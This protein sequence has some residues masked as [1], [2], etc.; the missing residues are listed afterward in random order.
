MTGMI[1]LYKV[2]IWLE[3]HGDSPPEDLTPD[4][5][6]RGPHRPSQDPSSLDDSRVSACSAM[7]ISTTLSVALASLG[8][9]SHIAVLF[10]LAFQR[11]LQPPY[12]PSPRI[13]GNASFRRRLSQ[14][15]P[16]LGILSA[17]VSVLT[18]YGIT[19][20][21]PLSQCALRVV[22]FFYACQVL[23]L[24]LTKAASP[25]TKLIRPGKGDGGAEPQP[26][27]M[28]TT[29]DHAS[30]VW[31]LLTEMRY[32]SFD[33]HVPQAGR[34]T[35]PDTPDPH[36]WIYGPLILL[37]ALTYLL[38]I[39]P[40]KSAL[41][42]LV[43]QHSLETLHTLLHPRCPDTLFSRPFS[44]A[45]LAEFWGERW[46]ASASP[47]LQSLAYKPVRKRTGSRAMGVLATFALTGLWH[48]Y[49]A[50]PIS[51]RPWVVGVR[52]WAWFVSQGVGCLVEM[53]VW[54]K[55]QGDWVQRACV[56]GFALG[57]AGVC[58]RA[59]ECSCAYEGLRRWACG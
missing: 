20:A 5:V 55:R 47:F 18:P 30:Y 40:L 25:P 14:I 10:L 45:S 32:R 31:A 35:T 37:P 12:S 17:G 11:G 48:A 44:A 15:I 46:H 13:Q 24:A 29:R 41:L 56:W 1:R 6:T 4:T 26:A 49:A 52:V 53:A 42:L 21:D 8:I 57:G 7:P 54:G 27:P 38:P 9:A 28:A 43:I 34:T 19:S 3:S 50:A 59:A 16:P 22:A 2:V 23:D 39:A 51:T 36:L 58:W 33:I